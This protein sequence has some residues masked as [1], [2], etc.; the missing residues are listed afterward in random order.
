MSV[1]PGGWSGSRPREEGDSTVVEWESNFEPKGASAEEAAK[2][3]QGI[4]QA[5]LDNLKKL[6]GGK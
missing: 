6:Y 2:T 1:A 4:F 3:I 5:G